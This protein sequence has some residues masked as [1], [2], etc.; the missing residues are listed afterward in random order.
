MNTLTFIGWLLWVPVA[1][2]GAYLLIFALLG[3]R[4]RPESH[5]ASEDR[6]PPARIAVLVPAYK[7]DAVI[8]DT[9]RRLLGISYARDF[10]DLVIIG[11]HLQPETAQAL[12]SMPLTFIELALTDSTK[13]K[14]LNEALRQLKKPYDMAMVLD[15]D[16]VVE[17]EVLADFN[18]A[19]YT[20]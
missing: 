17:P 15:A 4:R 12:R 19:P 2:T 7:E 11:D 10:W 9:A 20:I 14:A 6:N 13:A 5:S 18:R 8:L 1:M 3:L 16:N